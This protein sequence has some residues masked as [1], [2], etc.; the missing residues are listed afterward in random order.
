MDNQTNANIIRK[1]KK[2]QD[3]MQ[4]ID[5]DIGQNNCIYGTPGEG[6][7][8]W[9][10]LQA[11]IIELSLAVREHNVYL[12]YETE[13]EDISDPTYEATAFCGYGCEWTKEGFIR[14]VLPP[15]LKRREGY[16]KAGKSELNHYLRACLT[17]RCLSSSDPQ[18]FKKAVV[19]FKHIR[20][21]D[22][23]AQDYDNLE[24]KCVLDMVRNFYLEDDC[25]QFIDVYECCHE[26]DANFLVV[27]ILPQSAFGCFLDNYKNQPEEKLEFVEKDT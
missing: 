15:L 8:R 25:M 4:L 9:E 17:P 19:V 26:G 23:P 24:K 13:G 3:T 22:A 14:A 11:D 27:Y 18:V 21:P 6:Y 12:R 1:L 7:K 16:A 10:K 5:S 20:T 2:V